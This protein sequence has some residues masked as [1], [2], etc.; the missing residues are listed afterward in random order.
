MRWFKHDCDM[1]TDLKIQNLIAKHSTDGYT[2]W[3]LCLELLGK[4]GKK[5]LLNSKSGWQNG[6][7]KV[8]G[9][10]DNGKLTTILETM[11]ELNLINSKS[12]KYGN[13]YVPKFIKRADDYTTRLLR[14]NSEQDTNNVCVDKN[15]IE[16]IRTEYIRIKG[17]SLKNLSKNDY[18]RLGKAIKTLLERTKGEVE[19]IIKGLAW[20]SKQNYS[21]T[22][23]TLD[24]KWIEFTANPQ[25]PKGGAEAREL[26]GY[27]P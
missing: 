11:A 24:K 19:P 5:G 1:H 8:V 13:L 14:T 6:L 25:T 23:E 2:I 3:V 7:L 12:L 4:E 16:Q 18:G 21:W 26:K 22:L 10:S 15:R 9:W 20:I 17:Y 27:S